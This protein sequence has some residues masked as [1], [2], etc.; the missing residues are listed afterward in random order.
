MAGQP[1]R[2]ALGHLTMSSPIGRTSSTR[3]IAV[4]G[5]PGKGFHLT[6]A[7]VLRLAPPVSRRTIMAAIADKSLRGYPGIQGTGRSLPIPAVI[8]WLETIGIDTARLARFVADLEE[9]YARI[10]PTIYQIHQLAEAKRARR[11]A[12]K[13]AAQNPEREF[14]PCLKA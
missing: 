1:D 11:A 12:K 6:V 3:P 7:D 5:K 10:I 4:G 8:K 13:A 2:P 14:V 9:Q